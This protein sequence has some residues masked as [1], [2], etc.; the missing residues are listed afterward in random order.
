MDQVKYFETWFEVWYFFSFFY[1]K[2]LGK[3]KR[4]IVFM[5]TLFVL[6]SGQKYPWFERVKMF[7]K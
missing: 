5:E 1:D 6:C 7:S 3:T 4:Q 2:K